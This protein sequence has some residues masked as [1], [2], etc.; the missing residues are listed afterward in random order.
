MCFRGWG[1]SCKQVQTQSLLFAS[2]YVLE[3]EVAL[4]Q[5]PEA[6]HRDRGRKRTVCIF[7]VMEATIVD[8][9]AE[10][11]MYRVRSKGAWDGT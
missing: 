6:H 5:G 4:K 1:D 10:E 9:M 11:S 7:M 3:A 8:E 2:T